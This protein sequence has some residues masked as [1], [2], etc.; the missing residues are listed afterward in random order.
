VTEPERTARENAERM[1]RP[2]QAGFHPGIPGRLR[3][4]GWAVLDLADA[5]RDVAAA[6]RERPRRPVRRGSAR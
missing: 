3:G 5:M 2:D 6:L 4:V 1:L